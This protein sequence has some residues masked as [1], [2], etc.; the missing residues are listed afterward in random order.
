MPGGVRYSLL[1][2]IALVILIAHPAAGQGQGWGSPAGQGAR[3]EARLEL[4]VSTA[5]YAILALDLGAV[6]LETIEEDGRQY[7]VLTAPGLDDAAMPGYPRLPQ[8]GVL[9]GLPPGGPEYVS[10]GPEYVSGGDWSIQIVSGEE[11][12]AHV[13]RLD[14]PLARVPAFDPV[15]PGF[16]LDAPAPRLDPAAEEIDATDAF[17]P[18][19]PVTVQGTATLRDL[20]ILSLTLSPFRY[21]PVRGELVYVERLVVRVDFEQA[22]GSESTGTSSRPADAWDPVLKRAVLNYDVARE[23]RGI[24][25]GSRRTVDGL[26]LNSAADPSTSRAVTPGSVKIEVDADGLYQIGYDDLLAA[27]FPVETIDPRDLHLQVGGQELAAWLPG[28]EDGRFD[29]GD[30]LLFYGQAAGSR[31]TT[32]NVYWLNVDG[33]PGL[34][35]EQHDVTPADLYPLPPAHQTVRRFEE[36]LL[37]DSHHPEANG[38]HWYWTDLSF[39]QT[40]CPTAT[41]VYEFDLPHLETG[42][43]TATLGIGLQGS[44]PGSHHL[45]AWLN[46][47]QVGEIVWADQGRHDVEFILDA[48]WLADESNRLRLEN[49]A[50]P[51]P[52]PPSPPPNGMVLNYFTIE[53]PAGYL[54]QDGMLSFWGAPDPHQYEV[55]GLAGADPAREVLAREVLAREVLGVLFDITDPALPVR[56]TGARLEA[57]RGY[58]AGRLVFQDAR[59]GQFHYLAIAQTAIRAPQA[60]YVDTPSGL[61]SPSNGADYLLIGYGEFLPAAG[62]LLALRAGQ[63]L[64]TMAVD[65]Q[66]VY[67][68]F[69]A[70]VLTPQAIHDFLAHAVAQWQR[71][72]TYVLLLG[73]GTIDYLDHLEHGWHNFVPAYPAGVDPYQGE[74]AT[75]NRLACVAGEDNLPDLHIGRLPVSSAEQAQAVVTKIVGYETTE[76]PGVWSQRITL[77]A[78]D[79][80]AGLFR[81]YSND[82]YA[83]LDEPFSADRIYLTSPATWAHEYDPDDAADMA[84]A[85][86]ALRTRFDQGRLV[87]TYMGHSSPSQWAEERLWHRDDVPALQNA[88]RLPVVLSLTCYTGAFHHPPYAPLDERMAVAADGGAVAA[89]GATGAGVT[90][91]HR[92]LAQGFFDTALARTAGGETTTLGSATY[93]GK[94]KVYRQAPVYRDLVDT[95]VLLGDPATVLQAYLGAVHTVYLPLI[96]RK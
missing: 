90:T 30:R 92:Y 15:P 31:Y 73:D 19:S 67:D 47:H 77:V 91:G 76:L 59:E 54:A 10:G 88:G 55:D 11:R 1:I 25:P 56:L 18:A 8:M 85:R 94:V 82:L 46:D 29:P 26:T 45:A 16:G 69:S 74:T 81:Q 21:N 33:T 20:R 87:V 96:A 95:Y 28:E 17:Y 78:D 60:L 72:P 63:G 36:N 13:I 49:G 64:Q 79:D 48:S 71:A 41:Q 84:A 9:L 44:T 58:S 52:P 37:Y 66:D 5:E 6:E 62:P 65:V 34:R 80:A 22:E 83:G 7:V 75:D 93:A 23:W 39:L 38:D 68:E 50:C 53:Y 32:Q 61:A 3:E 2:G 70:G 27:G 51:P 40:G 43:Y 4:L 14:H 24:G 35:M 57:S 12:V 86:A 89:W 42:T